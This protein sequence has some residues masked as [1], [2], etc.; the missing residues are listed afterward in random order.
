[1]ISNLHNLAAAVINGI[2]HTDGIIDAI[3]AQCSGNY[4]VRLENY[5]IIGYRLIESKGSDREHQKYD[6]SSIS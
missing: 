4:P 5:L 3:V 6:D 1:M 2:L